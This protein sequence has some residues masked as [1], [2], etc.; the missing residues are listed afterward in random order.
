MLWGIRDLYIKEF[1]DTLALISQIE[2]PV[3]WGRDTE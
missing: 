3:N 1:P 2:N